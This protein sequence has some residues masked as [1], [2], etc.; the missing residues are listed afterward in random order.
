MTGCQLGWVYTANQITGM[1]LRYST[2][3][4]EYFDRK[5][6]FGFTKTYIESIDW[7]RLGLGDSN[8]YSQSSLFKNLY[9]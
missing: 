9:K 7:N 4:V 3:V 8:E 2:R 1:S 6:Y 5:K